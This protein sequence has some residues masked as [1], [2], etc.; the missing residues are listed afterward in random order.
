ME[1]VWEKNPS[2]KLHNLIPGDTFVTGDAYYIVTNS[3]FYPAPLPDEIVCVNL[4]T[5]EIAIFKSTDIVFM[6]KLVAMVRK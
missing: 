3:K 1:I 6:T 4:D 5:G 2:T